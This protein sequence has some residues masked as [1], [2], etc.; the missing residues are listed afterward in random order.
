MMEMEKKMEKVMEKM[1]EKKFGEV[2]KNVEKVDVEIKDAIWISEYKIGLREM[3]INK[4][5]SYTYIYL[6]YFN[7]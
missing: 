4:G 5:S 1:V 7:F 6:L 2:G 3:D